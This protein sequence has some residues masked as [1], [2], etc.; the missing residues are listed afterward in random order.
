MEPEVPML[1]DGTCGTDDI[2]EILDRMQANCPQPSSN[3]RQL[4]QLRRAPNVAGRNRSRE[5]LLEKS[6]AMLAGHGHMAGWFNQCPAASGIGES[7]RYR[8]RSIDL[9][10]WRPADSRL[11]LVE[12][13]WNSDTPA[14]AVRQIL[15]YGAAYLFCR[16]HRDRLPVGRRRAMSAGHVALRVAAPRRYYADDGF[17][18]C[19]AR[20]RESLRSIGRESGTQGLSMSLDALAFPGWFDRLPFGDGAEGRDACDRPELTEKG[21]IVVDAFDGLSSVISDRKGAGA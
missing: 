2:V 21:R 13:K 10:H 5:T 11:S 20:A 6:V 15:R 12:L 7:A 19:L 17:R 9:V 4:W 18:D 1:F 16:R 8:R 14:E 3:S